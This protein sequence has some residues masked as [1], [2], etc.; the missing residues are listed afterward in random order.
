MRIGY[1]NDFGLTFLG[2]RLDLRSCGGI[3]GHAQ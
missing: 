2:R 3:L 1:R